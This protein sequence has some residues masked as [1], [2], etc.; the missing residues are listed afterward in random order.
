MNT[1]HYLLISGI[2][3]GVIGS[4]LTALLASPVTAQRDK[5]GHIECTGL[6][7]VDGGRVEVIGK[8][9]QVILGIDELGGWVSVLRANRK[10][11]GLG[12]PSYDS[13]VTIYGKNTTNLVAFLDSNKHGAGRVEVFDGDGGLSVVSLEGEEHGGY[14]NVNGYVIVTSKDILQNDGIVTLYVDEHGG[15]AFALDNDGERSLSFGSEEYG[16]AVRAYDKAGQTTAFFGSSINGNGNVGVVG[17][18]GQGS[19]GFVIDEHGNADFSIVG[20]DGKPMV[21]LNID[22]HDGGSVRTFSKDGKSQALLGATEHGGVVMVSG[23]DGKPRGA[24]TVLEHEGSVTVIGKD[25]RSNFLLP[26]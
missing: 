1:K 22:E 20:S 5:F 2:V 10:G 16:G 13:L 6:T 18:H 4:L 12:V 15:S 11:V 7:V 14:V 19:G 24:L 23:K 17:K 21:R 26:Q 3:G 8:D 9:G 25:G